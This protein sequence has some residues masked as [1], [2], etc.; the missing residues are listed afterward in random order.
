[1]H[2]F[3][4]CRLKCK[5]KLGAL[6]FLLYG[7]TDREDIRYVYS[8]FPNVERLEIQVTIAGID[9]QQA[10]QCGV[11]ILFHDINLAAIE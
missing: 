4:T 11:S 2:G 5:P 3:L 7:I 6:S 10:G 8:T 1:M 9:L